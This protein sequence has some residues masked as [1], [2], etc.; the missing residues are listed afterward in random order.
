MRFD[1]PVVGVS[2]IAA[3]KAAG[4]TAA[5]GGRA[6]DADDRRRGDHQGRGRGGDRHRRPLQQR[7]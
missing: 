3:M 5:V 6:E 4:A 7:R 2:T 1:V